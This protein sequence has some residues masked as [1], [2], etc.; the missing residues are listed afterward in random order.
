MRKKK[1][2]KV[3]AADLTAGR[4]VLIEGD[5]RKIIKVD[6]VMHIPKDAGGITV[7]SE[8]LVYVEID[9]S[10]VARLLEGPVEVM[11]EAA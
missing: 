8:M 3:L 9:G 2:N 10:T 6:P 4:L 5:F 7:S 11:E 1:A